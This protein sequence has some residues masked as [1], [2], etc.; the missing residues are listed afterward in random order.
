MGWGPRESAFIDKNNSSDCR[1]MD[2]HFVILSIINRCRCELLVFS[3]VRGG[4]ISDGF[5][6]TGVLESTEQKNKRPSHQAASVLIHEFPIRRGLKKKVLVLLSCS[7]K[8]LLH[9][10]PQP[11]LFLFPLSSCC[12]Q[13]QARGRKCAAIEVSSDP[14]RN[15]CIAETSDERE[16]THY[17]T[18]ATTSA[19]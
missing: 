3:V 10:Y 5:H 16:R 17:K 18:R 7:G 6:F 19:G 8:H 14:V 4:G 1:I 15:V 13:A 9:V 2:P 11:M 12:V